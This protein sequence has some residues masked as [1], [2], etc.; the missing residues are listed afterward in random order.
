MAASFYNS[1][2]FEVV[3]SQGAKITVPYEDTG[4]VSPTEVEAKEFTIPVSG[5]GGVIVW[6][7]TAAGEQITSFERMILIASLF[8]CEGERVLDIGADVATEYEGF[9][10][11]AGVPHVMSSAI[12][13]VNYTT[14]VFAGTNDLVEKVSIKNTDADNTA[15]V[16]MILVDDT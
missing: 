8:D 16:M 13:R 1:G 7:S 11:R 2:T 14:D 5:S 6:Q 15:K 3:T 10:L 4:P 12:G 9:Y